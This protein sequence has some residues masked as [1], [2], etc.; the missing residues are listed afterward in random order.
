MVQFVAAGAFQMPSSKPQGPMGAGPQGTAPKD[1]PFAP[2]VDTKSLPAFCRIAATLKPSSDSS[3]RIEVWLPTSGWN[4]KFLGLGN[5]GMAGSIVYAGG[6]ALGLTDAIRL[7]YAAANTDAGHDSAT[8]KTEGSFL[9]GHPEKLIDFGYR[10]NHEMTLKAK[11]LVKALYGKAPKHSYFIG[12]SLGSQEAMSEAKRYPEDYD[13]VIAGA[14]MN[15]VAQFNA[16]QI[17]PAVLISRDPS[18]AIPREKFSMIQS[19]VLKSCGSPREVQQG[20]LDNP[21]RCHFEPAS[22][23]CKNSE[24]A[25]CLTAPQAELLRQIYQGP[26]NPRTG[27]VIFPGPAPGAEGQLDMVAASSPH[28]ASLALYRYGVHQDA[29][30]DWKT[31]DFDKDVELAVQKIGPAMHTD[32]DLHAFFQ[33]GGKLMLYIGWEDYHNPL[34]TEHYYEDI[35]RN[36]GPDKTDSARLFVVPGMGHCLGGS[37]CSSFDKVATIDR[38][39]ESGKAPEQILS[40]KLVS[41]KTVRTRPLC[42]YP[43]VARYKGTG[44]LDDAASFVCAK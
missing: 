24:Q 15:S 43:R 25:D 4:G 35:I 37:G 6:M 39:V 27:K 30:W 19:A 28:P 18:K 11:A 26:I 17:W 40:S 41:G 32:A 3:I 31:M 13:G 12:C 1:N 34:D 33:R 20:Y 7:G 21:G 29:N 42:A 16:A 10:A 14:V 2:K 5:G 38:W 9:L 8:D 44:S 23:L 22:L 36:A